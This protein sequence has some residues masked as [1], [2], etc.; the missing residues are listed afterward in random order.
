MDE[1][2]GVHFLSVRF[3]SLLAWKF[4]KLTDLFV[5][6]FALHECYDLNNSLYLR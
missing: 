1:W 6:T 5:L 4:V 3:M 2:V